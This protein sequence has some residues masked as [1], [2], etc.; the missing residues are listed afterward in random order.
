MHSV[1]LHRCACKQAQPSQTGWVHW[2]V[3]NPVSSQGKCTAFSI[4]LSCDTVV[5]VPSTKFQSSPV[6]CNRK[7][8]KSCMVARRCKSPICFPILFFFAR[9]EPE[10]YHFNVMKTRTP[11][12]EHVKLNLCNLF[13]SFSSNEL[14]LPCKLSTYL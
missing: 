3:S 7:L 14:I 11:K 8:R 6:M 1:A 12:N 10:N 13:V 9:L 5:S 2:H 4:F